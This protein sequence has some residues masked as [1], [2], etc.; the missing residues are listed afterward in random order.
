MRWHDERIREATADLVGTVAYIK[1]MG[2]V[3]KPMRDDY[4]R[5]LMSRS[6]EIAQLARRVAE[7]EAQ[8]SAAL[9]TIEQACGQAE[10]TS[11]GRLYAEG[12]AP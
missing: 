10:P 6:A 3:I 12:C 7:L 9:A 5:A 11:D 4:E 1:L 2:R 8:L